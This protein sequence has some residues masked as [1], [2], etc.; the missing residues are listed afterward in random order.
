MLED[1]I[2]KADVGRSKRKPVAKPLEE[3]IDPRQQQKI[4]KAFGT[5]LFRKNWNYK[6]D[7]S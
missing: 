5:F 2:A 7:R 1:G 3:S 4:L 6:H